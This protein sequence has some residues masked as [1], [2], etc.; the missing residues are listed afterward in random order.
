MECPPYLE[1]CCRAHVHCVVG[2]LLEVDGLGATHHTAAGQQHA[3]LAVHDAACEGTRGQ[4]TQQSWNWSE[5]H[6]LHTQT[7][8]RTLTSS[9]VLMGLFAS[10]DVLPKQAM[11]NC[12]Q[13]CR[14]LQLMAE[15]DSLP[16]WIL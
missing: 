8:V 1:A 14:G 2:D 3:G 16:G 13:L 10:T 11:T 15:A 7:Q 4:T 9:L 6:P 5:T 12:H